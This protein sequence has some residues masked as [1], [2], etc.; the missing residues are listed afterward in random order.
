[1]RADLGDEMPK[2]ACR[3]AARDERGAVVVEASISIT[4]FMFAIMTLLS[5]IKIAY[6]QERMSIALDTATKQLGKY[7]NV[8]SAVGL[9]DALSGEGGISSTIADAVGGFLKD[10]GSEIGEYDYFG[11]GV[12]D[13]LSDA[14]GALEGD[15]IADVLK[16]LV[17]KGVVQKLMEHSLATTEQG[18]A[19][20]FMK[21]YRVKSYDIDPF[22]C[23]VLDGDNQI[24]IPMTFEISVI[25]L[26]NIDFSFKFIHC[27]Y[28]Q[29]WIGSK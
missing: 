2:A 26:L 15:S 10:V 7:A 12:G 23:H 3:S 9:N 22:S 1:M 18:S 29:A 25:K 27:A 11:T 24:F 19:E 21:R 6:A 14:G 16:S 4:V 8:Y 20:A 5:L 28:T 17:A 13:L